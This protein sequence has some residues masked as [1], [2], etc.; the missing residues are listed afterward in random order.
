MLV[1][2]TALRSLALGMAE[3]SKLDLSFPSS[4]STGQGPQ[5][6][7]LGGP[8]SLGMCSADPGHMGVG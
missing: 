4:A 6:S 7:D 3:A 5:Q 1:P 2:L 8:Q